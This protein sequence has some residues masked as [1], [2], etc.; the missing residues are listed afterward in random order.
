MVN[1]RTGKEILDGIK[2]DAVYW[3]IE[4]GMKS[5]V[6][7]QNIIVTGFGFKVT[8]VERNG[9][10]MATCTYLCDGSRSMYELD[11]KGA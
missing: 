5:P 3:S 8:T 10:R 1:D 9:K 4:N 6:D 11:K 7:A 2:Q